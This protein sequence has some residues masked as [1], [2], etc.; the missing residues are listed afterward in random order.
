MAHSG[1]AAGGAGSSGHHTSSSAGGSGGGSHAS[2]TGA[3]ATAATAVAPVAP[4]R[5]FAYA[6]SA[7][8]FRGR[9]RGVEEGEGGGGM[10]CCTI[11]DLPSPASPFT[12]ARRH[13][14]GHPPRAPR[15]GV[16]QRGGC[17]A[18]AFAPVPHRLRH[19]LPIPP[20]LRPQLLGA[21]AYKKTSLTD[22][23]LDD[24]GKAQA[25]T[26]GLRIREARMVVD[27]VF[28][29]PLTRTLE[30]G[31]LMFPDRGAA[32]GGGGGGGSGSSRGVPFYAVELCREAHG[33]HPCDQ[34]R[35]ISVVR[36]EF[37]HVDFSG[38]GTDEDTWHNPERRETVRE[39]A[40][41]CDKFLTFLRSRPE[42]NIVVVS[43]G[44]F[45]ETLLN[46][47][48]LFCTDD[49]LRLKR[50]ENAE[51]RRWVATARGPRRRAGRWGGGALA[52]GSK[53]VCP[54]RATPPAAI[55][56]ACLVAGSR[57]RGA[58]RAGWWWRWRRRPQWRAVLHVCV[59]PAAPGFV[60]LLLS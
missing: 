30:T 41:R 28:V 58:A 31:S 11:A 56:A 14:Q 38:V 7:G 1:G 22:A 35:P 18:C 57:K 54:F 43:H 20:C 40:I 55:A 12:R 53:L 4:P 24:T 46:R 48:G 49:S 8:A 15:A 47:C 2:H 37:P 25:T 16:P 34:R 52:D 36:K 21:A 10:L 51:M 44:V 45:L 60:L 23:R 5:P 26:L 19:P 6:F 3:A 9:R 50:F 13:R 29:S 33:G 59:R 17:G 27:I 39:V 32:G 42:R